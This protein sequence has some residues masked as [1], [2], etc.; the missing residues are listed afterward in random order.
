MDTAALLTRHTALLLDTAGRLD[1]LGTP[2]LCTGWS[3][4]HVLSHLA[5][6]AEGF[7]GAIRGVREGRDVPVYSNDA[8]RD[9]DIK[10]GATYDPGRILAELRESSQDLS[11]LLAT[12]GPE[13]DSPV[14]RTPAGLVFRLGDLPR[15]RLRE[16]AYHHIDLAAGFT[17]DD[18][19]PE[20]LDAFLH[21]EV[22]RLTPAARSAELGFLA[23][24]LAR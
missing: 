23:R 6:N 24:G 7:A 15:M 4:A 20:L 14:H 10:V 21:D 9:G 13:E 19:E 18:L 1:G 8:A 17:F 12:I 22:D 3:R 2:S 5:R 16:V 11:G